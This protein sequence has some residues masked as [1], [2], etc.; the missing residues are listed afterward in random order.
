MNLALLMNCNFQD[1]IFVVSSPFLPI[2]LSSFVIET[3]K[4]SDFSVICLRHS[5]SLIH[6]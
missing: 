2:L 1:T 4:I 6:I 3:E 5:N